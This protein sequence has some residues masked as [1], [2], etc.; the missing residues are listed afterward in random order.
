V[1]N[2]I[3]APSQREDGS[4]RFTEQFSLIRRVLF[5]R[6]LRLLPL[7][8]QIGAVECLSVLVQQVPSLLPL[9]DQHLLAFLS[10][11]LKMCSVA[12]GEMT[13]P[14]LIDCVVDKNGYVGGSSSSTSSYPKHASALFF[15]RAC[16]FTVDGVSV[17]VPEE[18]PAGVQL[19]VSAIVLLHSVICSYSD[20]FFDAEISTP[21]GTLSKSTLIAA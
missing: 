15:R 4:T 21:I 20:L 9:T 1:L 12:D 10:E 11:L 2:Y 14:S 5:S 17:H 3:I 13:D 8:Q 19:R 18:L 6:S 7:V 16:V